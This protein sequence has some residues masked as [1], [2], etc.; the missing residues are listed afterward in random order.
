MGPKDRGL[1]FVTS[2]SDSYTL[3]LLLKCD[4]YCATKTVKETGDNE[5]TGA[6]GFRPASA[7]RSKAVAK[8]RQAINPVMVA[9]T[10]FATENDFPH[11]QFVILATTPFDMCLAIQE[12]GR[13]GR[14]GKLA[15]CYIIPTWMLHLPPGPRNNDLQGRKAMTDMIW[16]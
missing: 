5:R 12:M 11:V 4:F 16:K 14:D 9:T 2:V 7:L 6:K 10:A 13:A 1:V 8:W 3:A 15:F